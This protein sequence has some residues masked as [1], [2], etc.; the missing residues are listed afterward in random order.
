M[1]VSTE[2][3]SKEMWKLEKKKKQITLLIRPKKR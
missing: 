3:C 1:N 2:R